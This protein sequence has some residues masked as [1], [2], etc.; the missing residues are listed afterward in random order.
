LIEDL[1]NREEK[2]FGGGGAE[3]KKK[4][5]NGGGVKAKIKKKFKLSLSLLYLP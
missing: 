4:V 5:I 1:K 3:K 2:K